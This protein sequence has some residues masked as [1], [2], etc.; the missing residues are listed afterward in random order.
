MN[1][2]RSLEFV[3]SALPLKKKSFPNTASELAR[4]QKCKQEKKRNTCKKQSSLF[5]FVLLYRAF[6]VPPLCI[7]SRVR[8]KFETYNLIMRCK[9]IRIQMSLWH[10]QMVDSAEDLTSCHWIAFFSAFSHLHLVQN[11][12][13]STICWCQCDIQIKKYCF[14]TYSRTAKL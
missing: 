4:G 14:I 6:G 5:I 2:Q 11:S 8:S 10:Q 1:K 9:E 7:Y 12:A 13:S 3:T